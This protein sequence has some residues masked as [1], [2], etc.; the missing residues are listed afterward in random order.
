MAKMHWGWVAIT[1]GMLT[2]GG[3]VAG[4][5]ALI[6]DIATRVGILEKSRLEQKDDLNYIRG[7][8]DEIYNRLPNCGQCK[9]EK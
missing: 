1:V 7:R 5:A 8:V 4:V 2:I 9:D 3:K 6:A